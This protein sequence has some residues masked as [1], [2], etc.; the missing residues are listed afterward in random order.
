LHILVTADSRWQPAWSRASGPGSQGS[1]APE[2]ASRAGGNLGEAPRIRDVVAR[3]HFAL[4]SKKFPHHLLWSEL[5]SPRTRG[6]ALVYARLVYL[7]L[8]DL[9]FAFAFAT[10][11]WLE[12]FSSRVGACLIQD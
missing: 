10:G 5:A 3:G 4:A 1:A 6:D 8:S 2:S 12:S 9:N 7:W 11:N